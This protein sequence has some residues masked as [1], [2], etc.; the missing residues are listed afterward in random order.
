MTKLCNLVQQREGTPTSHSILKM[1][2]MSYALSSSLTKAG[3]YYEI[4]LKLQKGD[5]L[6]P[7][8]SLLPDTYTKQNKNCTVPYQ[9]ARQALYSAQQYLQ[10]VI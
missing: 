9:K 5:S 7:A 3:N 1:S 2:F 4:N 10:K 8:L 6:I